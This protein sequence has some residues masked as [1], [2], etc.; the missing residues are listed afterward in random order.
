MVNATTSHRHGWEIRSYWQHT[1]QYALDPNLPDVDFFEGALNMQGV[2]V[3]AAYGLTD[4]LIAVFRYG[5]ASR[6]NSLLGTANS[7]TGDIPQ[8]N[9][10]NDYNIYQMDLT[11]RF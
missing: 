3:A 5:H 6:I 2:Y 1:E 10:I 9:P 11:L 8:I 7:D 4:N